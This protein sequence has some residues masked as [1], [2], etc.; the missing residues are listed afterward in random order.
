MTDNKRLV[1]KIFD[2]DSIIHTVDKDLLHAEFGALDRGRITDVFEWGIYANS[3]RL[4]FIDKTSVFDSYDDRALPQF[5]IK[6]YLV[7][8][9]IETIIG[10]FKTTEINFV[11]ETSEV[12]IECVSM[13]VDWQNTH[14]RGIVYPYI[15]KAAIDFFEE[16]DAYSYLKIGIGEDDIGLNNTIIYCPYF[17]REPIWSSI[18]KICQATMCRVADDENGNPVISGSFPKKRP[19]IIMPSNIIEIPSREVA[20]AKG[21]GLQMTVTDRVKFENEVVGGDTFSVHYNDQNDPTS[22]SSGDSSAASSFTFSFIQDS[23]DI[24]ASITKKTDVRHKIYEVTKGNAFASV[25]RTIQWD[26]NEYSGGSNS[27][28]GFLKNSQVTKDS[29]DSLEIKMVVPIKDKLTAS[30][31]GNVTYGAR[32]TQ[33]IETKYYCSYFKDE[34]DIVEYYGKETGENQIPSN[35]LIQTKSYFGGDGE[36]P[37]AVHIIEETIKKYGKGILCFEI[38]CLFNDY[39]YEDGE[40]AFDR[41]DL[42]SHFKRYDVVIPY[43]NKKGGIVP[44]ATDTDGYPSK[45]RIIGIS[46]Y[47][48]GLLRQKLQLQEERD[49]SY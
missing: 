49:Y 11:E 14:T 1:A 32:L 27:I 43:V 23:D 17:P 24:Y 10:T 18:N 26:S 12:T 35:D 9:G 33:N 41:G 30:V 5:V 44:L 39:Y 19:I 8:N 36:T 25:K 37:L 42:S 7:Y 38:E 2:G 16:D 28:V 31:N 4:S 48:D 29:V 6:F 3:G 47:Y 20:T 21:K 22:I 45:F 15:K 46:Y 40:K 34:E 13:L